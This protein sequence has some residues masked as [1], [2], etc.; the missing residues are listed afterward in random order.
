MICNLIELQCLFKQGFLFAPQ[1]IGKFGPVVTLYTLNVKWKELDAFHKKPC[2]RKC[3]MLL[4]KGEITQSG[5]FIDRCI[6]IQFFTF[7]FAN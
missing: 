2:R 5:C 6:L 1:S 3:R 7:S 4:I